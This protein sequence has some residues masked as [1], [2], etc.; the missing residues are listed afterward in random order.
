MLYNNNNKKKRLGVQ[1][2]DIKTVTSVVQCCSLGFGFPKAVLASAK[3]ERVL[4]TTKET[5]S[6]FKTKQTNKQIATYVVHK[7]QK[8]QVWVILNVPE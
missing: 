4:K 6:S 8:D 5:L 2:C 1:T 3:E 7:L